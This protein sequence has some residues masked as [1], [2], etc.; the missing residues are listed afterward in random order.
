MTN[1]RIGSD[2]LQSRNTGEQ[3]A[4]SFFPLSMEK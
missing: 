4:A 2:L 1:F 3:E